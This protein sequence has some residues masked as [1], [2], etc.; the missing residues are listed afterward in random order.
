MS[1]VFGDMFAV[2][3]AVSN[4]PEVEMTEDSHTL[5]FIL[6]FMDPKKENPELRL[7]IAPQLLEA[8]RKY[9]LEE[10][11]EWMRI[12]IL[13]NSSVLRSATDLMNAAEAAHLLDVGTTYDVPELSKNA[14]R[15]LIRTP[16]EEL[17][18]SSAP[19]SSLYGHLTALRAERIDL[20]RRELL[21]INRLRRRTQSTFICVITPQDAI[22]WMNSAFALAAEPSLACLA[23]CSPQELED[24]SLVENISL[25]EAQLPDLP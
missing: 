14:L 24:R 11:K 19:K 21:Q 9:Q 1:P 15:V 17:A 23:R 12:W 6:Q 20:F 10:L 8:G 25:V 2:V 7:D 22:S 16:I 13:K 18:A 4:P 5:T 3:E